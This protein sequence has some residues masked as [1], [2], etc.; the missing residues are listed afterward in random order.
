MT[1]KELILKRIFAILEEIKE[2]DL[3]YRENDYLLNWDY[4]K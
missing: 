4:L 2:M 1:D 3:V